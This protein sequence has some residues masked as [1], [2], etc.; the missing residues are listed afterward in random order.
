M[1][2][3]VEHVGVLIDPCTNTSPSPTSGGKSCC[4]ACCSALRWTQHRSRGRRCPTL[5]RYRR[6]VSSFVV[7]A[8]VVLVLNWDVL[9]ERAERF[10][11][12]SSLHDFIQEKRNYIQVRQTPLKKV[13]MM[14]VPRT[15]ADSLRTHLFGS[16]SKTVL[17]DKSHWNFRHALC[18]SPPS[19]KNGLFDIK[20]DENSLFQ[21]YASRAYIVKAFLSAKDV[22]RIR[23]GTPQDTELTIFTLLR[24]PIERVISVYT[25]LSEH[26]CYYRHMTLVQ[27]LQSAATDPWVASLVN[28]GMTW[29]FAHTLYAPQRTEAGLSNEQALHS[30]KA[31]L[32]NNVTFVGF[33]ETIGS[34]FYTIKRKVFDNQITD[35]A[36]LERLWDM[37]CFFGFLRLRVRKYS[38]RLTVEEQ[39]LINDLTKQDQELYQYALVLRGLEGLVR[40]DSYSQIYRFVTG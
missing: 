40:P 11:K 25:F 33:Y 4:S 23:R 5:Y 17:Y 15:A 36:L 29:Q 1:E 16:T 37:G 35:N 7:L 27:F 13:V 30:A 6:L 18:G 28:N 32:T 24:D 2:R 22:R 26:H 12:H 8:V 9:S 31:F 39:Q 19:H 21:S 14:H 20:L 38:A 10:I 34:D 3:R